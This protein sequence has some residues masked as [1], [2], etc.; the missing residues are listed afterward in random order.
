V[1]CRASASFIATK[2]ARVRARIDPLKGISTPVKVSDCYSRVRPPASEVS[3]K[4][5]RPSKM[6]G[7]ARRPSH[8]T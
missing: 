2:P 4:L 7:R 1:V 6:P 8:S 3:V 5:C